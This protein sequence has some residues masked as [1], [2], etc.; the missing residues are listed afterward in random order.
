MTI[1]TNHKSAD[2]YDVYF[3]GVGGQGVLTIGE[4]IA[5]AAYQKGFP[6]SFY[7]T[8]GMAQ[9]GGPVKAQLRIGRASVGPAIPERSADLVIASEVSE[10]LK[11]VR[12]IKPDGDFVLYG[13]IWQP[14]A[15]VLGKASYP[16]LD[17]VLEVIRE[18]T[19]GIHFIAPENLPTFQE[20]PVPDNI[21]TLAVA[22][23]RTR[24][25]VL[26]QPADVEQILV[27]RWKKSLERNLF[28]FRAGL[29]F[30]G[31]TLVR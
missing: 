13:E 24:L 16:A 23:R 6:V 4:I 25:G 10:A 20:A 28:A 30:A 15:V 7:P 5:E 27:T 8:K 29:E 17:P 3:V 18:A 21:F 31:A 1:L 14:A 9:R 26:L 11:A 22:L 2:S 19:G 12:F